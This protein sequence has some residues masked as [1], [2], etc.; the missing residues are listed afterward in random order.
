MLTRRG[1]LAAGAATLAAP[2]L[3]VRAADMPPIVFVHGDSDLAATW[4]T[5]IWRFESNGYPRE[6]LFAISFTNPQGSIAAPKPEDNVSLPEDERRELA[7]FVDAALAKTGASKVA[8][9]A[10]SRGCNTTRNYLRHGGA[11]KAS[12]AVLCGGVNHGVFVGLGPES[13]YNP[14]SPFM[15]DLNSGP[16]ETTPGVKFLTLRSDGFDLYAQ[17]DGANLGAP[18]VATGTSAE[19][20]ALK[21]AENLTLGDVDHRG[22]A[23]SPRAF[24]EIWRFILGAAPGRIAIE[25]EDEVTLNGRVTGVVGAIVTNKPVAGAKVEIYEVDPD[26]G[27]RQGEALLS[28]TTAEDGVWGPLTTDSDTTLE[29][30]VTA[31]GHPIT[32]IYRSAFPRSFDKL[33]L[34]PA[35][36]SEMKADAAAVVTMNRPRGYFGSP[37]DAVF[38]D[39]KVP[40]GLPPGVPRVWRLP[41]T[42]ASVEDRGIICE[43]GEERIVARMWP[44]KDKHISIAELTY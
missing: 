44:M 13:E 33:D 41:A 39:G 16:D 20:P 11:E 18:G 15:A 5:V 3:R 31:D 12:H 19:G 28:K 40:G 32:H 25:E 38:I 6:K 35:L 30:V 2:M 42:F 26:T 4:E 22:T 17:A 9:V 24:P 37:R 27:E 7:A 43:C 8:I 29:F 36:D 21:G 23:L 10:L 34:R 1:F 14:K